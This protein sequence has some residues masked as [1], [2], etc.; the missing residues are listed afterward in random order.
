MK[1]KPVL[2]NSDFIL[3]KLCD[4]KDTKHSFLKMAYWFW[5]GLSHADSMS[6]S[7]PLLCCWSICCCASYMWKSH[8]GT[9]VLPFRSSSQSL[10][11]VSSDMHW[12]SSHMQWRDT[13]N[14]S[15][16]MQA[17]GLINTAERLH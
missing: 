1:Y 11:Y 3:A 12:S 17:V 9:W 14:T 4:M 7:E 13:S 10:G 15:L 8:A 16:A 6:C 5:N 2:T